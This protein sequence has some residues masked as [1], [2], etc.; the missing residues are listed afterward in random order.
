[1]YLV[2]SVFDSPFVCEPD[3]LQCRT[4]W[5]T[6]GHC[7]VYP[8]PEAITVDICIILALIIVIINIIDGF[9]AK[10]VI[11]I[12]KMNGQISP[13]KDAIVVRIVHHF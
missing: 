13:R 1:M 12:F 2:F 7:S 5:N 9:T 10:A 8:F 11:M 3:L 4:I 6:S